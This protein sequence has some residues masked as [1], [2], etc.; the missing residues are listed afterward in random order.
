MRA[1]FPLLLVLSVGC[2]SGGEFPGP[3]RPYKNKV[4]A[5]PGTI[6]AEDFDEG[7]EGVAYHD[8]SPGNSG[9]LYRSTDVDIAAAADSPAGYTLG[10]VVA[11]EWLKYTVSVAA[12]GS[13]A[14]EA[15]VASQG[16]GGTFHVE[17]DGVDATGPVAVPSSGGWQTWTSIAAGNVS[18]TAGAH[19]V[20]VVFDSI[21]ATGWWGNLNYLRWTRVTQSAP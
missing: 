13:Y 12:A 21:G 7:G 9:G 20:R 18:L 8:L 1:L 3:S 17:V 6:E 10:Y 16:P 4:H 15:R 14:L 11:G 2:A 5:I 19:V